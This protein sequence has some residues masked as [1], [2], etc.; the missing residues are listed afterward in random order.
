MV[1]TLVNV[2]KIHRNVICV[3]TKSDEFRTKFSNRNTC[4][5]RREIGDGVENIEDK[6]FH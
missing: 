3:V 5:E 6:Q 1:F 4:E 2:S